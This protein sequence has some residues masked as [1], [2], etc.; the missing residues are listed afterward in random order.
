MRS[1]E[2][3]L[4]E[5]PDSFPREGGASPLT[6][7]DL[8]RGALGNP[9]DLVS[10]EVPGAACDELQI[11]DVCCCVAA[12]GIVGA[13]VDPFGAKFPGGAADEAVELRMRILAE[14]R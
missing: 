10:G 1:R 4:K 14:L 8:R 2:R 12:D 6:K 7:P 3:I 11:A 5:R 9:G 13:P